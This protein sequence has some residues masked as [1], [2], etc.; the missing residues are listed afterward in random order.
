MLLDSEVSL[1]DIHSSTGTRFGQPGFVCGSSSG[2]GSVGM[3]QLSGKQQ[4]IDANTQS[5]RLAPRR[6]PPA[7]GV[8]PPSSSSSSSSTSLSGQASVQIQS[9]PSATEAPGPR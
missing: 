5:S 8:S 2:S 4:S 1:A 7:S 3:Q 9:S 6:L